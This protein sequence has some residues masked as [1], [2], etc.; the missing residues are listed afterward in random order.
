VPSV[1]RIQT[2]ATERIEALILDGS[3]VPLAGK[4]DILVSIR[5][6]SDGYFLDWNDDTFKASGWTTRQVAMTEVSATN[7]PGEY[8]RALDTSAI[9][10]Q[11][12]DD[13]YEIRVDQSPG[14]DAKNLPQV[15]EIKVGQ[16]VDELDAAVSS[17]AAPG[18]EMALVD[19]AIEAGKFDESTAFPLKDDDS[20]A[21]QVARTGAD[22]DTLET[23]SDQLDVAQADLDNPNQYKA[24][25]SALALEANVEGHAADA[26]TTYDPPT[27]AEATSDKNEILAAIPTASSVADAVWDE[28]MAGHTTGGTAGEQQN[29][30]DADISSRAT[31]ADILADAT[32]FNGAD[33]DAAISSRSS[34]SAADVDTVLTA[35]HG[36]GS[37]QTADLST[38]PA[39]VADAV[40]DEALAGHVTGGS[41]G[42]AVGRVD[43]QVSTRS[44]HT[45]ADVD[46]ALSASHG[47][48]SW[49]PASLASI[50]SAVWEELLAAHTTPG[51]TGLAQNRIDVAVSSRS[52]HTPADVDTQL[53]GSH[54][55]GSWQSDS[56]A[57]ADAVWDELLAGH[58]AAGSA[59]QAMARVDATVSSRAVPG[60]AMDLIANAVDSAS[61]AASGVNEIRDGIL[62]D[63]TPFA[64][65]R[66]DAAISSRSSHTPADVDAQLSGNHGAGSWESGPT[67]SQIAD[68]VWDEALAGH[69][70][71]G[72][73]GQAQARV[74]VAV[75][76]RS[77]HTP[78]DVDTE[79][80]ATH[81]A[82][83]WNTGDP[84]A[85]ADAVWDEALAGHVVAGSAGQAMG[86]VDVA[87]SSRS[88]HSAT[89]VDTVLTAAHGAGSWQAASVDPSVIADAVW[90]EASADHMTENT[91][92]GLQNR[93]DVGS[94]WG[95]GL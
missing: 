55:A 60:D 21:T 24:D 36:A 76:S 61:L 66:I 89:D 4:T 92:G 19:D 23:L 49:Q 85:I 81:G 6:W 12:A 50:A 56:S 26:L 87:V 34:H 53:S 72:S 83:A 40:W 86:R 7:A 79:L 73:A 2:G 58:T 77:S 18:D 45:P 17:R 1:V 51:T 33:I 28:P 30:L 39:L 63:S 70:V 9:T 14:T 11:T 46:A 64:G 16:F 5:R 8:Y 67:T 82:G 47:A 59:G 62:S 93:R 90:D 65:A 32:P 57:V 48:G 74:D 52:S 27:R 78:A 25:V 91:M 3:L 15:G 71:A 94:P 43:V 13:T 88:S 22:G 31:Q 42:E 84:G 20:G 41:A 10:N 54:G 69:V 44:S 29:H 37:W 38:I 75:S 80:T 35:A 95:T 68:A